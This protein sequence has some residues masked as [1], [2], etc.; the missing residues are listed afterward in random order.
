MR[1]TRKEFLGSLLAAGAATL[2][3]L[4]ALASDASAVPALPTAAARY[5]ALVN[6]SFWAKRPL[7]GD[8]AELVLLEVVR[9]EF[10]GRL[11][12]FSLHFLAPRDRLVEGPYFLEHKEAGESMLFLARLSEDSAGIRYR[13][14]FSLLPGAQTTK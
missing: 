12:Q 9:K 14:D 1:V 7:P 4:P 2:S 10:P 3:G 6:T 5:Q 11:E 13:A 8:R